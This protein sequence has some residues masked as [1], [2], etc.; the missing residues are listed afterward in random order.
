MTTRLLM[1]QTSP[2]GAVREPPR[3]TIFRAVPSKHQLRSHFLE[4]THSLKSDSA[5]KPGPFLS[6]QHLRIEVALARAIS[7]TPTLEPLGGSEQ[8]SGDPSK[9]DQPRMRWLSAGQA[10]GGPPVPNPRSSAPGE[11]LER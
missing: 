9:L 8:S 7:M 1:S 4:V 3:G 10:T 2:Y 6:F 5:Q 11:Q